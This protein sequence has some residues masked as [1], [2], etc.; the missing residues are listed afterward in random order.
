LTFTVILYFNYTFI[1][2]FI[3]ITEN[4]C[5]DCHVP[6]AVQ[7]SASICLSCE[8]IDLR[9]LRVAAD[10]QFIELEAVTRLMLAVSKSIGSHWGMTFSLLQ[11]I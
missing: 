4:K 8:D 7:P 2:I 3:V 9:T 6:Q 5:M 11:Q 10:G 1:I